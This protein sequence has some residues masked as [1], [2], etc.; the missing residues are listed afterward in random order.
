MGPDLKGLSFKRQYTY[1]RPCEQTE[2]HQKICPVIQR[3]TAISV[4]QL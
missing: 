2:V 3:F 1:I 4:I